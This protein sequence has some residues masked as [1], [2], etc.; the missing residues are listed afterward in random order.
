[1]AGVVSLTVSVLSGHPPVIALL[2]YSLA[3]ICGMLAFAW[4]AILA[5]ERLR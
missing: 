2:L 5:E 4:Q 3:G 1:M